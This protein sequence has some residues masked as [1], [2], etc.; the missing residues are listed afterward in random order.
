MHWRQ[1]LYLLKISN[2]D[3][4]SK[5]SKNLM[6]LEETG[7][8]PLMSRRTCEELCHVRLIPSLALHTG[9]MWGKHCPEECS[10]NVVWDQQK[11]QS[12]LPPTLMPTPGPHPRPTE[13]ASGGWA[14]K[15]VFGDLSGDSDMQR[16]VR[17]SPVYLKSSTGQGSSPVRPGTALLEPQGHCDNSPRRPELTPGPKHSR[18]EA[19]G[20][21]MV[22]GIFLCFNQQL[23]SK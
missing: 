22:A 10:Q 2:G 17:M 12:P 19:G 4:F 11:Q 3:S 5:D 13:S 8:G 18:A 20:F 14:Q 21:T 6:K 9:L 23:F 15:Q 7:L 1:Q 16:S